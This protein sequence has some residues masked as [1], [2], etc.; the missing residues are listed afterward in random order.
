LSLLNLTEE[1]LKLLDDDDLAAFAARAQW[2]HNAWNRKQNGIL[3]PREQQG[4]QIPPADE[5]WEI[6]MFRAGRGFGK[7]LSLDTRIPTPDGWTTMADVNIGDTVFDEAGKPCN[8]TFVSDIHVP[9]KAY[10]LMFADGVY[11][12]ACSEHQWVTWTHAERKAFL[13]S[14]YEDTS[15]FPDNWPTWRL[16]RRVGGHPIPRIYPDSPGPQIRLTQDIA[17]T[18]TQGKRDDRNHCIPLTLPLELPDAALPVDPYVMGYWLGNGNN[19][20]GDVT[21]GSHKGDFDKNFITR[22][23]E[24]AGYRVV[25]H[26]RYERGHT[27]LSVPE[28]TVQL[29]ELGLVRDKRVLTKYLRG[30]VPQ[31]LA[32]LRGLMDSDGHATPRNVEFCTT[33]RNFAVA[34]LEL[35]RSLGQKPVLYEDRARLNGVDYGERF[36]ITW[37][38]TVNPFSLPR[39]AKIVDGMG[40]GKGFI[41][42][43]R[44][45]E[46]CDP[47]EPVPMRCISVDSPNS[48]YLA[49]DGMVPTH[50]TAALTEWLWW[51]MWRFPNMIGHYIAPTLSDVRGTS[52]EGAAGLLSKIPVECLKGESIEKS[53]NKST[54]EV[55]FKNG[56]LIRGFG[57]VEEASRLRGPQCHALAA[58]E[59]AQWNRPAGNLEQAMS[60]A[61]F[62][63]RLP[64]PDKTPARAVVGTTP[65]PIP[66]LKRFE[67]RPGL[68]IVTGSSFENLDSLSPTY[69]NTL[70]SMTGTLLGK[71]EVEGLYIDDES[72]QSIIKRKWIQLWP[73]T[74]KLPPFQFIIEAYDTASSED[75]FDVKKRETDPSASAVFGVFNTYHAFSDQE[76][77][78]M[79][80]RCKY[81]VLLCDYWAERLGLPELL[82]R[83]RKQHSI[84]W[85]DPGRRAD[86]S[87]IEDKSSGP[88]LR[89]FLARYGVPV[90]SYNPGRES[91][92]TRLHSVSPLL[93]Q[94][95]LFVPESTRP[96]MKNQPRDWVV[97]FLEEL[98]AYAGPGTTDHDEAVDITSMAFSY[99]RDRN[100]LEAMP[101][102]AF[103]D[104]EHKLNEDRAEAKRI[105]I[106]SRIKPIVNPYG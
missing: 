92:T 28:L 57:A 79:G 101:E 61:L 62:G 71:Q 73:H 29:R 72:D 77:K 42:L 83:A 46:R 22:Q 52:F 69:R 60:N 18:L 68:R 86:V 82:E 44:M 17:D 48:L 31:R 4:K 80:L 94:N 78:K 25:A 50:N 2:I 88:G 95:M 38:P 9:D 21:S 70:L 98:C 11:I 13:R 16:Q 36:R 105:S 87:L 15:K 100:I 54:H 3:L 81:A 12:D 23:F 104:L 6:T 39:K 8:V 64:Y 32:L 75:N 14:P 65:L 19:A 40:A 106:Q 1:E 63:L 84:K 35:T 59:I 27:M 74:R 30:S 53:Y 91:K 103:T 96:D 55:R 56:S 10:R 33:Q 97:P 7:E 51:E 45:I 5:D 49:G 37:R 26:D 66:F 41:N 102:E 58:D 89:Q 20:N 99:L 47:V 67:K 90:S 76:R 93:N 34:V 24:D 43:H 85:G